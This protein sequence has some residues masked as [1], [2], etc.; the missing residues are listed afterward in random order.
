[1]DSYDAEE[2]V[3]SEDDFR[4]AIDMCCR[5]QE[6]E[7]AYVNAPKG[8]RMYLGLLFYLIHFG[9]RADDQLIRGILAEIEPE[10][11]MGDVNYLIGS[12]VVCEEEKKYLLK[13]RQTILNRQ[14][15]YVP[16]PAVM[17]AAQKKVKFQ[18]LD[19][20]TLKTMEEKR[21][22]KEKLLDIG[23]VLVKAVATIVVVCF[24]GW[25]VRITWTEIKRIEQQKLETGQQKEFKQK[26]REMEAEV[27]SLT[28][29]LK[30][31]ERTAQQDRQRADEMKSKYEK[32]R[33]N[34]KSDIERITAD[35]KLKLDELTRV[36][37]EIS[38]ELAQLRNMPHTGSGGVRTHGTN[39]PAK[40][41]R[42]TRPEIN[43]PVDI[44][45]PVL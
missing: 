30:V 29:A 6:M 24:I 32:L 3:I 2:N 13:L 10:L 5:N 40:T 16:P 45:L 15:L 14:E 18:K 28:N 39:T 19:H 43:T 17:M 20:D 35:Y 1:M 33:Q 36:N 22:Y 38:A 26:I 9:D 31:A 37:E 34:Y 25:G 12:P 23:A 4:T 11:E 27:A 41:P 7:D 8:A 21:R 44:D 42:R